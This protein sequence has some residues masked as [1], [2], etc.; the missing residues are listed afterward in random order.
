MKLLLLSAALP[1]LSA[2]GGTVPMPSHQSQPN[3]VITIDREKPPV[4]DNV[5][6]LSS[7]SEMKVTV[8]TTDTVPITDPS[9]GDFEI[10]EPGNPDAENEDQRVPQG[11]QGQQRLI[12]AG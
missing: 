3:T 12:Q 1:L 4:D 5:P 10:G 11:F 6:K 2:C 7:P 9:K 8:P